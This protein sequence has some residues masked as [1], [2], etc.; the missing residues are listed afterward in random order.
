MSCNQAIAF[1]KLDDSKCNVLFVYWY[2][3]IGKDFFRS[4][5]RGVRQKNL[6][7]SMVKSIPVFKTPLGLQNQFAA[8][9]EKVESIKSRYKQSL[10][11]LETLYGALSQKAFKGEL[12]LSRVPLPSENPVTDA[13]TYPL[14]HDENPGSNHEQLL[15]VA[16]TKDD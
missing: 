4:K 10:T 9:V 12:D 3:Q 5:Q 11:D 16:E 7:L 15:M 6:N 13:Q 1:S 2:I 14:A 8:I